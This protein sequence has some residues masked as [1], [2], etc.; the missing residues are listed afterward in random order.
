MPSDKKAAG[1]RIIVDVNCNILWIF[2]NIFDLW[3]IIDNGGAE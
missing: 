2:S 3:K 1:D